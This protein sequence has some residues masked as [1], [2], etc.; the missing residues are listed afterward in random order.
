MQ[1]SRRKTER[2][3]NGEK[4]DNQRQLYHIDSRQATTSTDSDGAESRPCPLLAKFTDTFVNFMVVVATGRTG[5]TTLPHCNNYE[6]FSGMNPATRS[7][8]QLVM[9][10]DMM[11]AR[12]WD[13]NWELPVASCQLK[14]PQLI[15]NK[16]QQLFNTFAKSWHTLLFCVHVRVHVH[17]RWS[18]LPSTWPLSVSDFIGKLLWYTLHSFPLL[19]LPLFVYLCVALS[20]SYF[21]AIIIS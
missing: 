7:R 6:S 14:H 2:G 1:E 3:R 4:C 8:Q 20:K 19:L 17:V 11:M 21:M 13:A 10:M 18:M 16:R 5:S 9:I 15:T 12:S